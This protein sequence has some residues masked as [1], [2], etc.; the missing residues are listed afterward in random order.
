MKTKTVQ[1][2]NTQNRLTSAT[3]ENT[4]TVILIAGLVV[5]AVATILPQEVFASSILEGC[6]LTCHFDLPLHAG[7]SLTCT[8]EVSEPEP[9]PE[10]EFDWNGD[11]LEDP[12]QDLKGGGQDPIV[13]GNWTY[14]EPGNGHKCANSPNPFDFDNDGFKE[15]MCY[16]YS[17][18]TKILFVDF[19]GNKQLDNGYELLNAENYANAF[20]IIRSDPNLCVNTH[21]YIWQDINSNILVDDGELQEHNKVFDISEYEEYP[22][23]YKLKENDRVVYAKVYEQ[24]L[25]ESLYATKPTYWMKGI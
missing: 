13:F 24:N 21:C 15:H 7:C 22:H 10:P 17:K 4:L 5:F 20:E 23:G 18:D 2:N 9:E 12:D 3:T 25:D 11:G 19:N 8:L 16:W 14:I 6:V 1:K